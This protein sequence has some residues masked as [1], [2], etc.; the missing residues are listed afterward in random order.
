MDTKVM[1]VI[2]NMKHSKLLK[3]IKGVIYEYAIL[4]CIEKTEKCGYTCV[5]IQ[6]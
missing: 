3:I 2:L 6:S 4:N 1:I 5:S